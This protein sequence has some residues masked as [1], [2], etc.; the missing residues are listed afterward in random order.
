MRS[1]VVFPAPLGPSSATNS[2]GWISSETPRKATRNPNRFST[3]SNR[4]P[5][6]RMPGE[7]D[8]P[9]ADKAIRSILYQIMQ[10][11]LDTRV[12]AGILLFANRAGL[13]AQF[14]TEEAFLHLVETAMNFTV[15]IRHN[16]GF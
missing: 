13:A 9:G 3:R 5:Q 11:L 16:S 8:V 4:K 1:S 6:H 12:F 14:K 10:E 2:P 15:H 7:G